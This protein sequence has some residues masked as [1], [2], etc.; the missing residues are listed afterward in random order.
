MSKMRKSLAV[1]SSAIA[2]ILYFS[3]PVMADLNAVTVTQPTDFVAASGNFPAL[4]AWPTSPTYG[5]APIIDSANNIFGTTNRNENNQVGT[6][7]NTGSGT[8]VQ[9]NPGGM[10]GETF[11][12]GASAGFTLGGISLWWSAAGNTA[13]G[14]TTGYTA[15][16]HLFQLTPGFSPQGATSTP[17][18]LATSQVGNDLLGSG[19]GLTYTAPLAG[20]G[21]KILEFDFTNATT[22]D[23]VVLSPNTTYEFEVW[24]SPSN[25]STNNFTVERQGGTAPYLGGE[26]YNVPTAA[27]STLLQSK[28]PDN[29]PRSSSG[30]RTMEF[31]V[32]PAVVTGAAFWNLST[33]G[34][35]DG[36]PNW[37]NGTVPDGVGAEA[38]F[39]SKTSTFN[40]PPTKNGLTAAG[41]VF[42]DQAR[43][44]GI[45][46]FDN[47]NG[48]VLDGNGSLTLSVASGNA[49]VNVISGTQEINLP[50]TIASPTVFSVASG[51]T[52]KISDPI[53][54][55]AGQSLTKTGTGTVTYQSTITVLSGGSIGFSAP[56]QVTS[57]ALVGS[58]SAVLSN[59][60]A[61]PENL[62]QLDSLSTDTTST[63]D[64][65]NNAMILH[66]GPLVST[67]VQL[68]SVETAIKNHSVISST[69]AGDTRHLTTLG[70]MQSNGG[71]FDG[72]NTTTNDVLL[73]YT[74]FGDADLNG[75]IN[76]ADY[77][78]IDSGYGAH[79]S[80]W[81]HGDFNND[82]VIDGTDFALI[83]N[84]FN[85]IAATGATPLA[86]VSNQASFSSSS[87]AVP[88][89]TTLGLLGVGAL[90]LLGRRRRTV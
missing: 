52:L 45:M 39:L 55:N 74:Y 49:L 62:L 80:G 82:G 69:A 12:T 90:S 60:G 3:A 26:Y 57:L 84:A 79:L 10:M 2:P 30:A 64:V 29:R 17:L 14:A 25:P 73:K 66:G 76:G 44:I 11:T 59:H 5:S 4:T 61:N 58:A 19:N 51:A 32:Y 40:T 68:S 31:A 1:L 9:M 56:S 16:L 77:A 21:P 15:T 85:Q 78:Q 18:V 22:N 37:S 88:E 24:D 13:A 86:L 48:Y 33:S 70:Y 7:S 50:L 43:T 34:S 20:E 42:T 35:W 71:M 28:S 23:Q 67:S 83:D 89:P 63:V 81:S 8:G 54:I 6:P 72:V 46:N 75:T 36:A 41:N 87:S 53:T 65:T 38:D 27:D 47:T